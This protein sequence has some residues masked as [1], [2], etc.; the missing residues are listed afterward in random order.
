M[1]NMVDLHVGDLATV[2]SKFK[3][4]NA[5]PH[6]LTVIVAENGG[7]VSLYSHHVEILDPHQK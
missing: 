7:K 4:S 2:D 1:Y 3:I 5:H 6:L